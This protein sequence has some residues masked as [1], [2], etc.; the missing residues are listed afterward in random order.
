MES[1]IL[2]SVDLMLLNKGFDNLTVSDKNEL[3]KSI[4]SKKGV[5]YSEVTNTEVLS[6]HKF[7]KDVHLS[8]LCRQD[9]L[10]GFV[11]ETNGHTYRT[12]EHDQINFMA[13]NLKLL[14]DD[15][16]EIIKHKTEDAGY[17]DHT[18]SE[19]LSV[20]EE[21]YAHV[22]NKLFRLDDLRTQIED[23]T[24]HDELVAIVW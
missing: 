3:I 18:R 9:I 2:N 13:R 17:V 1:Y 19:Y 14:R 11:S 21:G 16:I 6:H 10:N 12:N 5:V 23:A 22:E 20:Y 24:I 4:A 15:T 8:N 7:I